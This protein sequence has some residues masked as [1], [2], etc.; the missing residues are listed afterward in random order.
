MGCTWQ[1]G[2]ED[3]VVPN[4]GGLLF[5]PFSG[6]DDRSNPMRSQ[7]GAKTTTERQAKGIFLMWRFAGELGKKNPN[8]HP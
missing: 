7:P 8:T 5:S 6:S 1:R 2:Q 3:A 4:E